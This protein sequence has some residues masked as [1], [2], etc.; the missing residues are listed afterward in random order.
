[1]SSTAVEK[2]ALTG[3]AAHFGER[4]G[5]KARLFGAWYAAEHRLLTMKAFANTIVATSIFNP[6][7]YLFALGI[8]IGSYVDRGSGGALFGVSYLTFVGPALLA[9]ASINAVFEE[10]SYPVMGGF[11][12][13]REFYAMHAAP[14]RPGQ[15]ASGVLIAAMIRS[16][17]TVLV[18][19]IM[20]KLFGTLSSTR[21][22]LII[23]AAVFCGMGIGSVMAALAA[24]L[25]DDDGWFALINRM[26]I[27]P[28]FLFSG[29]FYPLEQMP[30]WLRWIG[31]IS[32]LWHGT[33]F[34]RWAGFNHPV[35][36]WLVAVHVVYL[37]SLAGFGWFLASKRFARRLEE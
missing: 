1:M 8:G 5:S 25:K 10:T 22:V 9:S 16:V 13:T 37:V 6:L 20:L 4:R 2:K 28:M 32:P 11:K 30:I 7:M 26:I 34:G 23:P 17:F 21:A 35:E 15:I 27:A 18:F 12:W 14:L 31:W 36:P 19:W 24:S 29:T 33:S 3:A